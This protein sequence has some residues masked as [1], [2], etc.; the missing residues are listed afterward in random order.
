MFDIPVGQR[1]FRP[2]LRRGFATCPQPGWT[3]YRALQKYINVYL[4]PSFL[5]RA[6]YQE[7]FGVNFD[8]F[9]DLR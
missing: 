9:W 4:L 6:K 8:N 5:P 2:F 1:M 7:V 3:L